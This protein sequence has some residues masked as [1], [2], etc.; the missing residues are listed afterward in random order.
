MLIYLIISLITLYMMAIMPRMLSRRDF[1][2]FSERYYAHRGLFDNK[3]NAPENSLTAFKLAIDND[4]GIELDVRLTKDNIP[5]VFHDLSLK[6]VCGLDKKVRE[7]NYS[8]LHELTLFKSKEKIPLFTDVLKLLEDKVPV[9]VELKT[10]GT[11]ISVC[12]IISPILDDFKGIYCVE[13]FNPS[14]LYWYKKNR[15]NI[16]RGQL[17]TNYLRDGIKNDFILYFVLQ[18]LLLNFINKPDFIA[19]NYKHSNMLSYRICK[20]IYKAPTFAYTIGSQEVL[21]EHINDFDYFI[22]EGFIPIPNKKQ[23]SE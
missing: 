17:S 22:F 16:I 7:L 13:S 18:N 11:D 6:R 10:T 12:E 19:F 8:E 9:I 20:Y 15:P 23:N 1:S 4:Y 3:T 21:D 5:V 14:I 2:A